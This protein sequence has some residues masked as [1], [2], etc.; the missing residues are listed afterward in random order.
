MSVEPAIREDAF[1]L[2]RLNWIALAVLALFDG[3]IHP[4]AGFSLELDQ[5]AWGGLSF[6]AALVAAG[7]FLLWRNCFRLAFIAL[8]VA[9]L[10]FLAL[11]GAMLTYIAASVNLPLQDQAL[12]H[13]DKMLG[14]D[15]A[16]YYRFMVSR[17]ELLPYFYLAYLALALPPFGVPIVLGLTKNYVRLQSF[18]LATLITIFVVSFLSAL[19]PAIGTYQLYNLP[20]EFAG[21]KASGYLIQLE[22]LPLIRSGSTCMSSTSRRL[23]ESLH[24]PVSTP[25]QL[26]SPYGHGGAFGGCAP[27]RS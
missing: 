7:H 6:S 3:V 19:M 15:W 17:P 22:R 11:L 20:T 4:I 24:S 1:R 25:Q 10:G 18:T 2:Y 8:S 23:A 5:A 26:S 12:D 14:M 9:Q 21:F 16:A 13:W 27:G